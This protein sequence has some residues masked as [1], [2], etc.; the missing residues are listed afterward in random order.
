MSAN[1]TVCAFFLLWSTV[2]ATAQIPEIKAQVTT[3][4]EVEGNVA[5]VEVAAHFVTA[6]HM[7]ETVNSV[8]VGAPALS[9]VEPSDREP[10]LVFVKALTPKPAE[11]NLLISTTHGH[12]V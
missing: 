10:Q 9:E 3:R 4:P 11:T 2:T 1:R 7:P 12:E 6:I 5:T 8:V